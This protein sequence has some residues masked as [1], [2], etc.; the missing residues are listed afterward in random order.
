MDIHTV[1]AGGGSIARVDEGGSLR[2]GPESAGADPGPACYGRSMLPTV[3]DAHVVL[4]HFGGAGLLGGE[5]QLDE[6]RAR[7]A[8][9]MLGSEMS[10]VAGRKV[11]ITEAAQ[12]VISVVNTNMERALRSISVER[13]YDP[14][15]FALLPFGGAGGLHAVDLASALRIPRVIVPTAAG[16]LS[17]IGVV[18]AD[19][20]K[21]LAHG[22]AGSA[23]G[24][25]RSWNP[26][27]GNLSTS[28]ATHCARKDLQNRNSATK[29][30]WP[31][32]T[33]DNRSNSTLSHRKEAP[34]RSQRVFIAR[35][36]PGMVT[37]RNR[38][39]LR[40]SARS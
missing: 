6:Q 35:I 5:F 14:R 12:G 31:P 38:T 9:S 15:D 10:K 29:G 33:K 13:G 23:T 20:V 8:I 28:R 4:G 34:G 30:R 3:T 1:G 2:V 19:V 26:C 17:A 18:T 7:E 40:L 36:G 25:A 39:S 11:S 27:L 22:D 16:A 37:R 21:D 32:V 24:I